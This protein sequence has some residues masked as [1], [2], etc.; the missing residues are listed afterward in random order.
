MKQ[1]T[2]H[3]NPR[4][5]AILLLEHLDE[6]RQ[7][8]AGGGIRIR[9]VRIPAVLIIVGL[10]RLPEGQVKRGRGRVALALGLVRGG[11]G[12]RLGETRTRRFE[13]MRGRLHLRAQQTQE[14]LQDMQGR[15]TIKPGHTVDNCSHVRIYTL[16]PSY[17]PLACG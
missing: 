16:G 3:L 7:H 11:L 1:A 9:F 4:I 6:L 8:G 10:G 5:S 17:E 13:D 12:L 2:A 15:F 14:Q